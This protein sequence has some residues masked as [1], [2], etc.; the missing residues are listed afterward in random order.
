MEIIA[1]CIMINHV[2]LIF[3][4]IKGQHPSLL[5]GD[6]KRFTSKT[7]VKAIEQNPRESRKEFLLDQFKEL[8]QKSSNINGYQFWRHNSKPIELWSVVN[9]MT[10]IARERGEILEFYLLFQCFE[11][12]EV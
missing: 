2:H 1:W 11:L 7:V 8:L 3:R 12:N 9:L 4:S 6:F 5:L 10:L